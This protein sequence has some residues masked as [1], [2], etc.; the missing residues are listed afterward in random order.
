MGQTQADW[1]NREDQEWLGRWARRWATDPANRFC[2]PANPNALDRQLLSLFDSIEKCRDDIDT[3]LGSLHEAWKHSGV[4]T[5]T[6]YRLK[7]HYLFRGVGYEVAKR[8]GQLKT[9]SAEQTLQ[10]WNRLQNVYNGQDGTYRAAKAWIGP[11]SG[12]PS[13][14]MAR[15]RVEPKRRG[16]YVKGRG[17]YFPDGSRAEGPLV[18]LAMAINGTWRTW[19]ERR[20]A[21]QAAHPVPP[22]PLDTGRDADVVTDA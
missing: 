22:E 21:A 11:A 7:F 9:D 8:A 12:P 10:N 3:K 6:A 4:L 17:Y 5:K 20:A 15:V 19:R 13:D 18:D 14:D 1:M 2:D 16:T